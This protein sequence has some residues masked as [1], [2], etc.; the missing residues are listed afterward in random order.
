M[1]FEGAL[2]GLT[3]LSMPSFMHAVLIPLRT[4]PQNKALLGHVPCVTTDRS[5]PC[6]FRLIGT[7]PLCKTKQRARAASRFVSPLAA[8]VL[9]FVTML[10]LPNTRPERAHSGRHFSEDIVASRGEGIDNT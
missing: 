1:L 10:F 3:L 4:M 8:L 9:H 2:I 7:T 5:P 6:G